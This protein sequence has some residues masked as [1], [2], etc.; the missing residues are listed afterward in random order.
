VDPK[1][2]EEIAKRRASELNRLS[3][4][5]LVVCPIC[6]VTLSPHF[7]GEVKDVAEVIL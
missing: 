5:L 7:K 1:L 3:D 4:K 6:Y 2:S